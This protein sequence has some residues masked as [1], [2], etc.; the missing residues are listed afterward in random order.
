MCLLRI[1]CYLTRGGVMQPFGIAL[2]PQR[3]CLTDTLGSALV[4]WVTFCLLFRH[5]GTPIVFISWDFWEDEFWFVA[6]ELSVKECAYLLFE[7]A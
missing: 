1:N 5:M 7:M 2:A 3:D 4:S 6:V